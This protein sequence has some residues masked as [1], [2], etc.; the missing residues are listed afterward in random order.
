MMTEHYKHQQKFEPWKQQDIIETLYKRARWTSEPKEPRKMKR[1]ILCYPDN[2]TSADV[3]ES[4]K[5]WQEVKDSCSKP[6]PMYPAA[7]PEPQPVGPAGGSSI[8]RKKMF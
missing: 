7:R 4:D 8:P 2:K 3:Q 6:K 1:N 5:N